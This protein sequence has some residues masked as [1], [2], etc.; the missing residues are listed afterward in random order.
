MPPHAVSNGNY[1]FSADRPARVRRTAAEETRKE[2]YE[3]RGK[4]RAVPILGARLAGG[5]ASGSALS[6]KFA[7]ISRIGM[8]RL[9]IARYTFIR[10]RRLETTAAVR[11]TMGGYPFHRPK[12]SRKR[13]T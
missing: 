1:R 6:Q 13:F 9:P 3:L 4:T 7:F 10:A 8:S 2:E 5:D 12:Q 11:W